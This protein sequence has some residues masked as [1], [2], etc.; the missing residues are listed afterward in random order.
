MNDRIESQNVNLVTIVDSFSPTAGASSQ[1]PQLS[2]TVIAPFPKPNNVPLFQSSSSNTINAPSSCGNNV[3][4]NHSQIPSSTPST[5]SLSN[6][7]VP[8]LVLSTSSPNGEE[9]LYQYPRPYTRG[10]YDQKAAKDYSPHDSVES[11][12]NWS[13]RE[14]TVITKINKRL[15]NVSLV[16]R[17]HCDL[18]KSD[19]ALLISRLRKEMNLSRVEWI[20]FADVTTLWDYP[21][22]RLH[23]HFGFDTDI[24]PESMSMVFRGACERAFYRLVRRS[25]FQTEVEFQAI[26]SRRFLRD[27][28][29]PLRYG[30]DYSITG[31]QYVTDNDGNWSLFVRYSLNYEKSDYGIDPVPKYLKGGD[32]KK[33]RP[34][35]RLFRKYKRGTG[36]KSLPR[37]FYSAGWFVESTHQEQIR[38]YHEEQKKMALSFTQNDGRTPPVTGVRFDRW[39]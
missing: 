5:T 36:T 11:Y 37:L 18:S 19:Y 12:H 31:T 28:L 20:A 29:K 6:L 2:Y 15:A 39:D 4:N 17:F 23:F 10:R 24:S 14:F 30:I 16:L 25:D 34:L 1:H 8:S 3:A 26:I 35:I 22:N 7:T 9:L 38:Q 27:R 32:V 33:G 13:K 21:I